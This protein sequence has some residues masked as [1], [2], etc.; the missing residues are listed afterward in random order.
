MTI[1]NNRLDLTS[2][3]GNDSKSG[4]L[5]IYGFRFPH[6]DTIIEIIKKTRNPI[7]Y[8]VT[9]NKNGTFN[10]EIVVCIDLKLNE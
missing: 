4:M 3:Y 1:V 7:N 9:A 10:L 5:L 6:D 2:K 8:S